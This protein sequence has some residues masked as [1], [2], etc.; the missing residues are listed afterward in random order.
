M[1]ELQEKIARLPA[2]AREH[3]KRLEIQAQPNID[4]LVRLRGKVAQLEK[5]NRHLEDKVSAMIEIFQCAAKGGSEIATEVKKIVDAWVINE[6]E[7][8]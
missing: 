2:W 8:A 6:E 5:V 4:E 7:K 1:T 3:M